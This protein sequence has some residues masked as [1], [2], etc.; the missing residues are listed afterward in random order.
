MNDARF[1]RS[2]RVLR[3]YKLD[4]LPQ[5]F[6]VLFGEMSL[7]GPRPQVIY[8][9]K[10]YRGAERSI[11]SVKPGITDYAS[12][13]FSDMDKV[14]GK[15]NVDDKY[16]KEIEP[17]KNQLRIKYVN[18]RSLLVDL[19]ILVETFFLLFGISNITGLD[20]EV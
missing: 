12:I 14:L 4:E 6:N 13:Y 15:N 8:Y 17:L 7:V 19:R 10:K 9:T 16:E 3:K 5:L 20:I 1:T 11:L 2:G 18:E